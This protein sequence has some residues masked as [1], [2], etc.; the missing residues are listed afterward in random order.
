[1]GELGSTRRGVVTDKEEKERGR[2]RERIEAESNN[3]SV[4]ISYVV[5]R[6][7]GVLLY[8]SFYRV[9]CADYCTLSNKTLLLIH[10]FF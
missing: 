1:M 6:M 8:N 3:D 9:K 4:K 2:E 5:L 10:L 7:C